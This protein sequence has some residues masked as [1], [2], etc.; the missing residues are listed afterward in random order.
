VLLSF[1]E[2]LVLAKKRYRDYGSR[3]GQANL[4][5]TSDVA[6]LTADLVN[7]PSVS[8]DE[9]VLADAIESILKDCSWLTIE[10]IHNSLVAR[11]NLGRSSRVIV[12]GH[13]DT[14]PVADNDQAVVI[15]AGG[16]LPT[17]ESV[18]TETLFGLGSC[19]M[20]GGV[21]VALR[22]AV[23]I[24]EPVF[25]VTYVFYECEEVDSKRNGLTLISQARPELLEADIAILLEPSNAG[26]E[27]GCQGTLVARLTSLGVRSHSARSWKGVNAIHA[28]HEAINVLTA[29]KPRSVE[30]DGLTYREGLNAVR[31]D[32]GIANNV[33]PDSVT[34]NV[35]YRY[36]PN[37]TAQ[38]AE[39]HVRD[40]FSG[41]TVDI[42]DNVAG[43]M[44]GLDRPALAD[45]V[46]RVDGQVAPKFG[47]TD[48]ARF[49]AMGVP[50][51]NLGPGDPS[52]AH[53]RNEHVSM[54]QLQ[55]CEDTVFAWLQGK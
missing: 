3:V 35:N 14:V 44:P 13:I 43:A 25:D 21:A 42:I 27:A 24:N 47:W 34:M 4:H 41:Y 1:R 40:V 51:V 28:L 46:K 39:Q 11:T 36:A 15:P 30:I 29:Y 5:V 52:L 18:E 19:D 2:V 16:K 33:I 38:E 10:R 49:Y 32:G 20:K 37:R 17:G 22:A 26:I 7:F 9:K 53:A 45:L 6:T 54:A 23:L 8:G 48:V 55:Q 12:A 31:I 50:A